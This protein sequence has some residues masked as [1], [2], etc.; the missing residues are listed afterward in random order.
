[1]T[2]LD[3]AIAWL[4]ALLAPG[5]LPAAT[6]GEWAVDVGIRPRTLRRAKERLG[7]V[8]SKPDGWQ[9]A[10]ILALPT[11]APETEPVHADQVR[12]GLPGR[13]VDLPAS[14]VGDSYEA[15]NVLTGRRV[16]LSPTSAPRRVALRRVR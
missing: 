11:P 3:R 16:D 15:W 2:V 8:V 6:V 12:A 1:M 9:G 14:D 13:G 7:V 5:P 10:R 4:E